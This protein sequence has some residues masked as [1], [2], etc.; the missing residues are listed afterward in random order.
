MAIKL[1]LTTILSICLIA[2]SHT[3]SDQSM[4]AA[5]EQETKVS[6][7][8]VL[9]EIELVLVEAGEHC[10]VNISNQNSISLELAPPCYFART[11]KDQ[12]QTYD[13]PKQ[14]IDAVVLIIG[15]PANQS[16]RKKWGLKPKMHCGTK[17]QAL[18]LKG[19]AIFLSEKI[20][21]GGIGCTHSGN[22]EK[23]FWYFA[24]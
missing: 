11:S 17:R 19:G 24:H 10:L 14:G 13:Y 2:C 20:Q 1:A 4:T 8:A 21:E 18:L 9:G 5:L 22:D 23:V 15:D 6:D 7:S 3:S 12:L 16:Q